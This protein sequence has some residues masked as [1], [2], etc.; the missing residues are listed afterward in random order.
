MPTYIKGQEVE[1]RW[2]GDRW[3]PAT[4]E[5]VYDHGADVRVHDYGLNYVKFEDIRELPDTI[6]H[7]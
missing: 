3:L 7:G 1:I 2:E 5:R 6:L 4:I